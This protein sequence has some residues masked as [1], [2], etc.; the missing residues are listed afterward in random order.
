[1][2]FCCVFLYVRLFKPSVSGR[3]FVCETRITFFTPRA[4]WIEI[5][6]YHAPNAASYPSAQP[7]LLLSTTYVLSFVM[8][9]T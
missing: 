1:M 5:F 3:R 6:F 9:L 2:F 8:N 4:I 7:L